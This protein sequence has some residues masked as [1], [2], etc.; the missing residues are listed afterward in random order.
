MKDIV[1][2]LGPTASGKSGAALEVSKHIDCELI[3]AD[4]MQI[5]RKMDIGTAKPTKQEQEIVKHHMIDIVNIDEDFSVSDF[6]DKSFKIIDNLHKNNKTPVVVGGTGLYINS[7]VYDLDFTST[8]LNEDFRNEMEEIIRKKGLR[9]L[10]ERLKDL[11]S[12]AANRIH[13]ND[14]KR[15]IR[16][17]EVLDNE[18]NE[19]KK[20]DFEKINT[21]YNFKIFGLTHPRPFLYEKINNR[22]DIMLEKGLI[23]EVKGLVDEYGENHKALKAI[24]YKEIIDYLNGNISKEE[25]IRLVKRNSRRFAKR[26]FTWF[27]RDNRT[28]WLDFSEK[29]CLNYL[30]SGIK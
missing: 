8:P 11:D 21:K 18:G 20:F 7:I 25:A 17:L 6:K 29:N 15:I 27:K 28:K 2:I 4:S 30:I 12:D 5:Y 3:S 13:Q 9:S 1:V 16:R 26:Q 23:S 19:V 24:G 10:Y 14:E 22:V